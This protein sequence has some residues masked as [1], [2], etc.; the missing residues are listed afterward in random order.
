[1]IGDFHAQLLSMRE[2]DNIA[3]DV[4]Q[5]P[6]FGE[7][8]GSDVRLEALSFVNDVVFEQE[9]GL[10]ELLTAPYTFANSRIG[11][12]YGLDMPSPATGGSDAFIRVELEPTE[13]AGL[14][15]QIGFLAANGEGEIPNIIMRGVHIADKVL[16]VDLPAPPNN[17]PPLPPIEPSGTNRQ[18]VEDLTKEAACAGC[19]TALI[20]PPGFAFENLDGVGRYRT[21][22]NGLPIDATG[23]YKLDGELVTFDGAVEF[24]T[25]IAGSKQAHDCYARHWVEY[26]YGR[27]VDMKTDADLNLVRQGGWLSSSDSSVKNLIVNLLATDAF[28]TR[29]P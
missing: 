15:T 14:L 29:L 22:E 1:V 10:Y 12:L 20:N 6:A 24:T 23:S 9:L 19:H 21:E 28:L 25:A 8:V 11:Q 13:R 7:G 26:L 27:D 4:R 2:F 17:V 3:K 18:R 16:C 5:F